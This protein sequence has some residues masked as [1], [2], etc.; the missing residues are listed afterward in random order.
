[1]GI[2]V[3]YSLLLKAI[4][5]SPLEFRQKFW[6]PLV[7]EKLRQIIESPEINKALFD[8]FVEQRKENPCEAEMKGL[9]STLNM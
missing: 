2:A 8:R 9:K 6:H 5:T 1:M 3:R 7:W 4:N